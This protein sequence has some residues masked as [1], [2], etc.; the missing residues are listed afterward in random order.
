MKTHRYSL[1]VNVFSLSLLVGA[2]AC[3][4]ASD[5][6]EPGNTGGSGSSNS[7]GS[8]A[9]GG[10]SP[11]GSGGSSNTG[12]SG[13]GGSASGGGAGS[14]TGGSLGTGGSETGGTGGGSGGTSGA[15]GAGTDASASTGGAG[16][17]ADAGGME[18][19]TPPAGG[20]M[21]IKVEGLDMSPKYDAPVFPKTASHPDDMSPAISWT[22][23]PDGTKSFAV[24]MIDTGQT[25]GMKV[26]PGG[27]T[28]A[29]WVY[30]DIPTT[31]TGLPANLPHTATLTDPAGT[32][33]TKFAGG[34]GYFGPGAGS[35]NIYAITVWALK[36][37][38][39]GAAAGVASATAYGMLQA[40]SLG[41]ATFIV[42]GKLG[43]L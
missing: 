38:T 35:V 6:N 17:T 25:N 12:G 27:G 24:S 18:T 10:S 21:T 41:K 8:K 20:P 19:G 29:H 33:T 4:T 31:A 37:P 28:K 23:M 22:G 5:T 14:S 15:G 3:S 42:V 30:F 43:G 34:T 13:S 2:A 40:N 39:L 1:V 32:K 11:T 26:T 9:T 36:V 16:G 7:G